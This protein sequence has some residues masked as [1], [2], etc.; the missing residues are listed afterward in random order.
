VVDEKRR[1]LI[2]AYKR[3]AASADGELILAHLSGE[4]TE[5]RTTFYGDS[6]RLSIFAEGRRSVMLDIRALVATDLEALEKEPD[7]VV[8]GE[9]EDNG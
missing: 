6:E 4:C 9:E 3:F 5:N 2:L 8:T 7:K 1:N